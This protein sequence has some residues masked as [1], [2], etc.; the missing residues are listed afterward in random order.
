M[1]QSVVTVSSGTAD[2]VE[3]APL[4]CA[5]LGED[6]QNYLFECLPSDEDG[7][8]R[9]GFEHCVD[10]KGLPGHKY[11]EG[12]FH[13]MPGRHEQTVPSVHPRWGCPLDRRPAPLQLSAF[14]AAFRQVNAEMLCSLQRTVER[15]SKRRGLA[16]VMQRQ[17]C[18]ADLSVQIH[19]GDEVPTQQ[20]AWH[21]DA[22][23]SFLHLALGLQG[24]RALLAQRRKVPRVPGQPRSEV[25]TE[26]LWQ[27]PGAAYLSTPCCF[28]HAVH[29]PQTTWE[30]RIVA[31]QCRLLLTDDELFAVDNRE[32]LDTDPHAT[33]AQ[34]IFRHLSQAHLQIPSLAE[35]EAH[36]R[37][38]DESD[39]RTRASIHADGLQVQ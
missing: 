4:L 17:A 12:Y 21:V 16:P 32:A 2:L 13:A 1:G 11:M 20:A 25:G 8:E 10:I 15:I 34:A 31:V 19:W 29:Y 9:N 30:Q 3:E 18:F 14:C 36:H 26:T 35:V 6:L 22:P 23:N 28:P 27:E 33:L 24:R 37:R 7:F 5:V 39:F 38:M